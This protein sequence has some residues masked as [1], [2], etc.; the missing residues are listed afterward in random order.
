MHSTRT[1]E[2]SKTLSPLPPLI[3]AA[4][5]RPISG[6]RKWPLGKPPLGSSS[7]TGAR[8]SRGRR[9]ETSK[10]AAATGGAE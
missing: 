3:S 9:W 5:G 7:A 4:V 8:G 6:R 1:G 10:A 2:G